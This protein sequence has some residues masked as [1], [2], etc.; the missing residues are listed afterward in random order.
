[1]YTSMNMYT[2]IHGPVR[3]GIDTKIYTYIYIYIQKYKFMY[4]C[5][6]KMC[7]CVYL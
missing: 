2:G 4:M 1:M 6:C 5:I 3:G 7:V